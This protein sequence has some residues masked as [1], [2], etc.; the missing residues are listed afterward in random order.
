MNTVVFIEISTMSIWK[1]SFTIITIIIVHVT[2]T[3]IWTCNKH[4]FIKFKIELNNVGNTT[5]AL[6]GQ[7]EADNFFTF[8]QLIFHCIVIW[9]L[10]AFV[11]KTASGQLTLPTLSLFFDYLISI[12]SE[13]NVYMVLK[14]GS[15]LSIK[16]SNKPY[17][18]NCFISVR[19][20]AFP[21]CNFIND[22]VSI[23]VHISHI[24][25]GSKQWTRL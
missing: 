16:K 14:S 19:K 21:N 24:W 11:D 17:Y 9:N 20:R 23:T 8:F 2:C 1:E 7:L 3:C 4:L 5:Q 25:N 18:T 10:I 6:K 12:H 22:I 15:K 13:S